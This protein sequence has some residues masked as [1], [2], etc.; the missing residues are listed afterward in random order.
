MTFSL[1][2]RLTRLGPFLK[3]CY[4]ANTEVSKSYFDFCVCQRIYTNIQKV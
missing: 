2:F 4:G 3:P 1:L